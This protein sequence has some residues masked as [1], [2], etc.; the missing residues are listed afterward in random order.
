VRTDFYKCDITPAIGMERPST[1]HERLIERIN[2]PLKE[3]RK[4]CHSWE[5]TEEVIS[6]I[7]KL[8]GVKK[9]WKVHL[10]LW[11]IKPEA[12]MNDLRGDYFTMQRQDGLAASKNEFLAKKSQNF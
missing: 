11:A 8:E 10:K 12:K 1:Y 7:F 2:D 4:P 3:R 9:R 5:V 6:K